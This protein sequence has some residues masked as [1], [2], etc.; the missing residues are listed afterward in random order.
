MKKNVGGDKH[1]SV[2]DVGTLNVNERIPEVTLKKIYPFIQILTGTLMV[3]LV[4]NDFVELLFEFV[5]DVEK[6]KVP[7]EWSAGGWKF[8]FWMFDHQPAWYIWQGMIFIS[9]FVL[10][11]SGFF[12]FLPRTVNLGIVGG[13]IVTALF[14][15]LFPT[16]AYLV[17][18]T[19]KEFMWY[20][21]IAGAILV[22]GA[23]KSQNIK[24]V[25]TV[26]LYIA[27]FIMAAFLVV[28]LA[29]SIVTLIYGILPVIGVLFL[30]LTKKQFAS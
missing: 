1:F 3:V 6:L 16:V 8:K 26:G 2:I 7:I 12:K 28:T 11:F 27:A 14:V 24:H 13:L 4:V 29:T 23:L 10:I 20:Q 25:Q 19:P 18:Q 9:G 17:E 30:L 22:P 21:L 5:F 15:L